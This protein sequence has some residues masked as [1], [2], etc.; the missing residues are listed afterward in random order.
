MGAVPG[1]GA[2]GGDMGRSM[3]SWELG[4]KQGMQNSNVSGM[5]TPGGIS[6]DGRGG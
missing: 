5:V 4:A 6:K 2:Q 1:Q 3:S